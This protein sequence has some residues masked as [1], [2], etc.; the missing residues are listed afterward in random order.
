MHRKVALTAIAFVY[1]AVSATAL[2]NFNADLLVTALFLYGIPALVLAHFSLVPNPTMVAVA[3]LSVAVGVFM[4]GVAHAYGLW[5]VPADGMPLLLSFVPLSALFATVL[6][7]LF[8]VLL[9][10]LLFDDGVYRSFQARK[11]LGLFFAFAAVSII[12]IIFHELVLGQL[13]AVGGYVTLVSIIIGTACATLFI[14]RRFTLKLVERLFR[15]SALAAVPLLI[16]LTIAVLNQQKLFIEA[17]HYMAT[18]P[19]F[20]SHVPFEELFLLLALPF[21]IATVYELYLDDRT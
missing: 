21:F 14:E 8:L 12:L 3:A 15:F 1:Y 6:Q 20:G 5:L 11:K 9:Y 19:F 18:V 7:I 10:E 13:F 17:Q 2:Y 16:G 4:E